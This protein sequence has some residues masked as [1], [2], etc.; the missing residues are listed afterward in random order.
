M[1]TNNL[2]VLFQAKYQFDSAQKYY[3]MAVKIDPNAKKPKNNLGD[4]FIMK[5]LYYSKI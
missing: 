3:E 5:G 2:G 1:A 4:L